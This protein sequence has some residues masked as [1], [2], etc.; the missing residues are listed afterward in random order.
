M[1][2]T[3]NTYVEQIIRPT[4]LLDPTIEVRKTEGQIDDLLGE[5]RE[6]IAKNER[7]LI[8]T[9]TIRMAEELTN[10]L[11]EL[12][13]KVAYLHSEVKT[14][15]RMQI[16]HDVR[17]GKYDVL[18]GINLLREGLDIPE[19]SLIA[20]LDAD[21]EGFLRSTR[22]LIQTIGRCARNANGH[23][24]MYGD[25]I[26]DS[27]QEA[28]DETKRRR[29]IQEKYN[30]EHG[31]IPKTIEKEIRDVISNADMSENKKG[32]KKTIS[33]KEKEQI[34]ES[35]EQEMRE[36]AKS[37]NFERAMELRDILFEM[38]SND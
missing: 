7:T 29:S 12:D 3:S 9:L 10:Y 20:I 22:S 28:I 13:I 2:Y 18:V 36:A 19:V 35:I 31:I 24:I 17:A 1:E 32:K 21:K 23:V 25:K 15:E 6:R 26:T 5:I 37:L 4:G 11:K 34:M 8:T 27:M 14:L 33:K 30:E 38:K 16:I